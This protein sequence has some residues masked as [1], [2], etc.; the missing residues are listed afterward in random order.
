MTPSL[1]CL[2]W[3]PVSIQIVDIEGVPYLIIVQNK[4]E[5]SNSRF[6][7]GEG[8]CRFLYCTEE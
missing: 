3:V 6:E 8:I 5:A 1:A 2:L 7:W 4:A